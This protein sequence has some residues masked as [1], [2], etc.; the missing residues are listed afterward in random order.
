MLVGRALLSA[1]LVWLPLI[2]PAAANACSRVLWNDNSIA[3][4]SG[5]SAD[6]FKASDPKGASDPR[7]LVM[8][9]GLL[10]SGAKFGSELV[11]TE[12]PATWR[13]RYGSVVVSTQNTTVFDGMNE[14]GLAAHS[15]SLPVTDYGARDVS[16]QGIQMGLWVPYILDNAATVSEAIALL[17][18][19][20]PV[21]VL[22]DGFAMKLSLSIEDRFGDSAVIEYLNGAAVIRHSRQI[23]VMANTELSVAEA[24]LSNYNFNF[25]EATR[26]VPLPGNA[27]SLDRFVRASFFSGFLSNMNARNLQEARAAL[28]SVVRNVSNPIGAPGDTPGQGPLSG[29]ET[30]WRTVSDLTN[31]VYIFDNPRTLAIMSTDLRHLDFERGTGVRVLN[32]SNPRLSGDVTRLYR[33]SRSPVPGEA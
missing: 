5:R 21:A 3:V 11:V 9:R 27:N 17:P 29:D 2:T 25:Q 6:W 12:N 30:D 13:A 28:M 19:I 22:V 16:R 31:R 7:L 14:K 23:R 10:K 8:P 4:L 24:E 1:I 26:N 33:P 32:P 20:Q 15:L 18:R